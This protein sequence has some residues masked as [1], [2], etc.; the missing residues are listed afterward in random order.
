MADVAEA[1]GV[2]PITVSRA[3]SAPDS[4]SPETRRRIDEAVRKL[5]YVGNRAAG[6]LKS[7]RSNLV[8]V[9]IPSVTHHSLASMIQGLSEGLNASGY[10]LVLATSGDSREEEERLLRAF[11][12]QRPCAAVLHNTVHT[13]ECRRL[14]RSSGIP[15]IETGDLADEPLDVAIGYS[16]FEAARS[17]TRHLL[18]RGHRRVAFVYRW[19]ERNERTDA[20]MAGYRAAIEQ[21]GLPADDGLLFGSEAGVA[22]GAQTMLQ[23]LSERPD[24]DAV[25][26]TGNDAGAGG[27]LACRREG[28]DVPGR[29]AIAGY[30]DTGLAACLEPTLTTLHIPRREIGRAAAAAILA[31]LAGAEVARR[32]DLGFTLCAR[33]ST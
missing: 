11:L 19:A 6:S 1:A 13:A 9:V 7:R 28:W 17:M 33:A 4:V 31:R 18:D 24:V 10:H 27:I 5:G 25:F 23:I 2:A 12:A 8:V 21:A 26:F 15:V 22:G 32:Q 14:L 16:N 3:L 29:V 30:D 20:R